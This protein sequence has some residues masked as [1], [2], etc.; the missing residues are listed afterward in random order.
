MNYIN[1]FVKIKERLSDQRFT[2]QYLKIKDNDKV[3]KL[4]V[5]KQY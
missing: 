3:K 2:A 1:R 5:K 4:P